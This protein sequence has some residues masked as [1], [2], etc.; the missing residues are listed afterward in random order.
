MSPWP[1]QSEAKNQEELHEVLSQLDLLSASR[2]R[3][4]VCPCQSD[5]PGAQSFVRLSSGR[6]NRVS[7]CGLICT[8]STP[9]SVLSLAITGSV[10]G[11]KMH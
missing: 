3:D 11:L 8:T 4:M 7:S 6:F 9:K 10:H 1:S 5:E 2:A